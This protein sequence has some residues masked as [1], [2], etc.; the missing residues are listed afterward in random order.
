MINETV[1]YIQNKIKDYKPQIG[2]I[3]GSGLGDFANDFQ[4][5]KIIS[6]AEIPGFEKSTVIG[7]KG[8]LVFAEIKGKKT[9]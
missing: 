6:Y 8:Q 5:V 1:K 9:W 3:L 2:I 4:S 7:H